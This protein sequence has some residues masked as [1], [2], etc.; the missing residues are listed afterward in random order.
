M[1]MPLGS[2]CRRYPSSPMAGL[3]V[4]FT[5]KVMQSLSGLPMKAGRTCI[6]RSEL[7]MY[8]AVGVFWPRFS[9]QNLVLEESVKVRPFCTI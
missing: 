5:V 6:W 4:S 7:A 3:R 2:T 8:F 1:K 9:K